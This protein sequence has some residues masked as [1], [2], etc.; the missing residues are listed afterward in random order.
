[1]FS[2]NI[3]LV[4]KPEGDVNLLTLRPH[5][6]AVSM[7]GTF[8][9]LVYGIVACVVVWAFRFWVL[10]NFG[11]NDYLVFITLCFVMVALSLNVSFSSA[12][13]APM[14]ILVFLKIGSLKNACHNRP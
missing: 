6:L 1:M 2:Q 14:F 11:K 3:E 7:L 12:Y 9:W 8:G 5:N 10:R 4:F 13:Y